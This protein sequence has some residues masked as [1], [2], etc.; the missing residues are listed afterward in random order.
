MWTI[1]TGT[2]TKVFVGT[3]KDATGET[4]TTYKGTPAQIKAMALEL[5]E[6]EK[7]FLRGYR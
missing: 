1:A 6:A 2:K 4:V 3:Y 7:P 5:F